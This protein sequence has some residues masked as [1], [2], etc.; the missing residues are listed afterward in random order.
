MKKRLFIG[1]ILVAGFA[2]VTEARNPFGR[3]TT[4][5]YNTPSQRATQST[6]TQRVNTPSVMQENLLSPERMEKVYG[7]SILIRETTTPVNTVAQPE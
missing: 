2:T 4:S 7:P 5:R 6:P 3:R 1:L